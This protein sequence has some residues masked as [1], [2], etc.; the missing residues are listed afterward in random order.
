MLT[1]SNILADYGIKTCSEWSSIC[2]Q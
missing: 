2:E 1:I